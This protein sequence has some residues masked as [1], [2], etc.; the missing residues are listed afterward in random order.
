[1]GAYEA[2]ILSYMLAWLEANDRRFELR[3]AT[4][5][6]AGSINAMLA[7]L[8]HCS[9]DRSRPAADLFWRTWI[10]LGL[11]NLYVEKEVGM[12]SAFSR[13]WIEGMADQIA[14]RW[15]D[16]LD[17]SC[18]VV[19]GISATRVVPR[20][21][22]LAGGALRAP[23]I[24]E[25]FAVRIRGRGPGRTP[26]ITNYVE[27]EGAS[28]ALLLPEGPDGD[29]PFAALRDLLIAST[30]VPV[31]FEPVELASCAP[32]RGHGRPRCPQRDARTAYFIDGGVLDNSPLRMAA[33]LA[34]TGL[35]VPP[36]GGRMAWRE[37]ARAREARAPAGMR[38]AFISPD[39]TA[40][41]ARAESF[42]LDDQTSLLRLLG[43]EAASFLI[44][45]RAKNLNTLL[46]ESPEVADQVS[47]TSLH[48][49]A[50]SSPMAAFFGFFEREFRRYDF[51]LGMYD[52]RRALA[53]RDR[54]ADAGPPDAPE[55]FPED[56]PGADAQAWR[57]L[58]CLRA[59]FETPSASREACAGEDLRD[60][61]IL[62]Q[63]SL[64]R[65]YQE[66]AAAG[67]DTHVRRHPHCLAA[68][69]GEPP[70]RLPGVESAP[71]A[72]WRQAKGESEPAWV[73]RLLSEHHFHFQ[74]LGLDRDDADE[75]LRRIRLRLGSVVSRLAAAQPA[76]EG[77]AMEQ[78]GQVAAN[79]LLYV[80]SRN[81]AWL[82]FSRD[83]ELGWSNGVPTLPGL[84]GLLRFHLALQS[85]GL[86]DLLSSEKKP[87]GLAPLAGL[88]CVLPLSNAALQYGFFLRAGWLFSSGD[89]FGTGRCADPASN[90][91]GACSRFTAQAGAGVV[92][93]E[94]LRLQLLLETFP[95]LASGQ[96]TLWNVSPALGVQLAF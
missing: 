58:R 6:S 52:G 3:L 75:A 9:L 38:F 14:E 13:R 64:E 79:A 21:V 43:Q 65:L 80:P 32:V 69:A 41:P 23:R 88:G 42:H 59:A 19:L 16:G 11:S 89:D 24:E 4:G 77:L 70:P 95:A 28:D 72:D 94:I 15:R 74:D 51:Y 91:L 45:A 93:L 90:A 67:P 39:V 46:E 63:T 87:W 31:A 85:Y 81:V 30:A 55:V 48:F 22:E 37:L 5:A 2:G 76:G 20:N 18:D 36:G 8:S 60:F 35:H 10:P 92:A 56:A 7:I 82:A 12:R 25:H 96:R 71:G 54:S 27:A 83:V 34:R 49:P 84:G 86:Y 53:E 50:A 29:V 61:R 62:A 68:R 40:Y 66:C 44:T 47:V 26:R 78:L 17:G 1:M 57:P 73:V 33:G